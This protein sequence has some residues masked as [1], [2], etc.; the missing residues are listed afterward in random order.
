M[1]VFILKPTD[2]E[3]KFFGLKLSFFLLVFTQLILPFQFKVKVPPSTILPLLT[4]GLM[5]FMSPKSMT[6]FYYPIKALE[7]LIKKIISHVVLTLVFY[8]IVSP[9]AILK[10]LSGQDGLDKSFKDKQESYYQDARDEQIV[11]NMNRPF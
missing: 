5:G 1:S 2:R 9:L 11:D 6:L 3:L 4:L 10:R 8:F 7:R